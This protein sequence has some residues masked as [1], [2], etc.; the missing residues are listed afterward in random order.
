M[1]K[2]KGVMFPFFVEKMVCCNLDLGKD[3]EFPFFADALPR[4]WEEKV[5]VCV[6]RC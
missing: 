2:F 4:N 3:G 1:S 5:D 6:K